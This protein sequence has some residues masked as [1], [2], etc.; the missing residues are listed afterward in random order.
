FILGM[1]SLGIAIP[2]APAGLGVFEVAAVGA[3]SLLG[4]STSAG[5]AIA[6]VSHFISITFTGLVGMYGIFQDGENFAGLYR[7]LINLRMT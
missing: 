4:L 2:S 1:I 7:R 6:F 3:F 5:L